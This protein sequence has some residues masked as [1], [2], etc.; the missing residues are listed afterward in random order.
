[1][2]LRQTRRT[3]AF[4]TLLRRAANIFVKSAIRAGVAASRAGPARSGGDKGW[5]QAMND[6]PEKA[7]NGWAS[8]L[9][10]RSSIV[11]GGSKQRH[12]EKDADNAQ[13]RLDSAR[14]FPCVVYGGADAVARCVTLGF[15]RILRLMDAVGMCAEL[16]GHV[17]YVRYETLRR[18]PCRVECRR[19]A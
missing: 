2:P 1:M 18:W 12:S 3:S 5:G 7:D 13:R 17:G 4:T 14:A 10:A 11:G 15:L 8:D 16:Y 6:G 19:Q 9:H